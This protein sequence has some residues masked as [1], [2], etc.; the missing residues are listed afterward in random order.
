MFSAFFCKI[1][2]KLRRRNKSKKL[3][4]PRSLRLTMDE[5]IMKKLLK[6]QMRKTLEKDDS[7][8]I[9][10]LKI[11]LKILELAVLIIKI[12]SLTCFERTELELSSVNTTI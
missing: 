9:F 5:I 10:I 3:G 7:A 1:L 8:L 11:V 12:S 4:L 6:R 2:V